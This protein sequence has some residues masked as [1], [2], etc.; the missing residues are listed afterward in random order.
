MSRLREQLDP[1]SLLPVPIFI[2]GATGTGKEVLANYIHRR[3]PW[4][5]GSFIKVRCAT[6]P[7][8]LL[9]AE[10]FGIDQGTFTGAS[11]SQPPLIEL[12][13][14]GTLLLDDISGLDLS[15][16]AKLL[17]FLQNATSTRIEAPKRRHVST[18]IICTANPSFENHVERES[19]RQD[20]FQRIS[21][22]TF[23]LP[24]LRER[25]EDLP[26]IIEYLLSQFA[27]NLGIQVRPLSAALYRR[28]LTY[29]W[30]GNI[31]E[32][33]NVLRRYSLLGTPAAVLE[34]LKLRSDPVSVAN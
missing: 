31:R 8:S 28:L 19:S 1:V 26:C 25:L 15:S 32:L 9:E 24:P 21:G 6:I 22:V 4:K 33:E 7:G 27:K 10:L 34:G 2:Y 12:P 16:Q 11:N 17:H 23:A 5:D 18:R 13:R 14:S 20:F 3:S 30:P 29:P